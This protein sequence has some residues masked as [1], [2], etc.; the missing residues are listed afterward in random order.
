MRLCF[1]VLQLSL[2][3]RHFRSR[4]GHLLFR[5]RGRRMGCF[6][7]RGPGPFQAGSIGEVPCVPTAAAI[8]NAVVDAII[9][10]TAEGVVD[11]REPASSLQR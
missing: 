11:S 5:P 7:R 9:M 2:G 8:A 10:E 4:L 1:G 3:L 6:D